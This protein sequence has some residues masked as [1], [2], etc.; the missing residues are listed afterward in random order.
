MALWATCGRP[1]RLAGR[2]RRPLAWHGRLGYPGRVCEQRKRCERLIV[3]MLVRDIPETA[4]YPDTWQGVAGSFLV[5][6]VVKD[7]F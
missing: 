4:C 2:K 1:G 3:A 6:H 7:K 5:K